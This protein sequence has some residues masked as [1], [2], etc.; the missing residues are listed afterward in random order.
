MNVEN[1]HLG[2]P[3][4]QNCLG[5]NQLHCITLVAGCLRLFSFVDSIIVSFIFW[6]KILLQRS[7]NL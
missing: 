4:I 1:A 2:L 3:Y 5:A 6:T 7:S